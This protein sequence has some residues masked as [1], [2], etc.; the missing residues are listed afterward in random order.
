M[1]TLFLI[2]RYVIE[3]SKDTA[4]R[5]G[6]VQDLQ[7]VE[8]QKWKQSLAFFWSS[9]FDKICQFRCSDHLNS[10]QAS[11]VFY[12]ETIKD[13]LRNLAVRISGTLE[14]SLLRK[15]YEILFWLETSKNN[16][17]GEESALVLKSMCPS[18]SQKCPFIPRVA[19]FQKCRFVSWAL[20]VTLGW[21]RLTYF[22][23]RG[24]VF[25]TSKFFKILV[26]IFI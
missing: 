13:I 17:Y 1:R 16:H 22:L 12:L 9:K 25:T 8:S 10:F 4:G 5:N 11:V 23:H 26:T 15:I 18:T 21:N 2:C 6:K 24:G 20:S 3:A 19:L 7:D 14:K